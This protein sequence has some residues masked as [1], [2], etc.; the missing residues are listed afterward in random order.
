MKVFTIITQSLFIAYLLFLL[1]LVSI[2]LSVLA[3]TNTSLATATLVD[4]FPYVETNVNTTN[5]GSNLGMQGGCVAACCSTLVYKVITPSPGTLRVEMDPFV[6]LAGS[7]L[8]YEPN[9]P[10]PTTNADVTHSPAPGNF[11]GFRDT[12]QFYNVLTGEYYIY[13][14]NHNSQTGQ[15]TINT[16]TFTFTPDPNVSAL[17]PVICDTTAYISPAGN[18]LTTSGN[19]V[20]TLTGATV[21]GSDSLIY[22]NLTIGHT[23]YPQDS[24]QDETLNSTD[25][26]RHTA[27]TNLISTAT[28]TQ[29]DDDWIEVNGAVP[30]MAGTN[31]SIF[32]WMRKSTQVSGSSQTLLALNTSSGG[33]VSLFQVRTNEELG[34][35]DG[36][37]AH[38]SGQVV[39][40]GLWHHVGYTYDETTDSTLVYVDGVIVDRFRNSQTVSATNQLSIGQE[41]DSGN[42]RGNFYDGE[43]TE[44]SIWNEVLTEAEV[45]LLMESAITPS[46]PKYANLQAYYPMNLTCDGSIDSVYDHSGH[47]RTG[48]ASASDIQ[49][50]DS[51]VQLEGFDASS[52]FDIEWS[53]SPSQEWNF[54]ATTVS[55]SNPLNLTTFSEGTY[56]MKLSRDFFSITDSWNLTVNVL[57]IELSSFEGYIVEQGVKLL[58]ETASEQNNAAFTIERGQS[59][60]GHINWESI[61]TVE[62]AGT[63]TEAQQYDFLD[64]NP[65]SGESFY[66]LK[67]T[68]FNG[69][70]TYSDRIQV[71][72][73]QAFKK[74]GEF[75]PN[76]TETGLVQIIYPNPTSQDLRISVK[77]FDLEG[78]LH[79]EQIQHLSQGERTLSLDLSELKT[80]MY[81]VKLT[82]RSQTNHRKLIIR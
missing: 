60:A 65:L 82:D 49:N 29:A 16:L 11:C 63:T 59:D 54:S 19:Y 21:N 41:F 73:E 68:D 14:F 27:T 26:L 67:Q 50:A 51:L 34:I 78:K 71:F 8:L 44:V 15:G 6:P 61:G 10:N 39:T 32:T 46:H 13:I 25:T 23:V 1:A 20:D 75:Y 2:P 31:R 35:Y 80:G 69:S 53:Q 70:F 81:L 4:N 37:N 17:N 24:I 79:H 64:T 3:Q 55:T 36:S 77:V 47:N 12:L 18:V 5:G 58:W 45:A 57:P 42:S 30:S 56:N 62:G 9:V 74:I 48:F 7:I 52:H 28:F 66:R 40:D 33:N 43:M 22:I 38:S 76:P 72:T